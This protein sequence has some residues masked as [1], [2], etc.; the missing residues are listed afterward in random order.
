MTLTKEKLIVVGAI[1][2]LAVVALGFEKPSESSEL[3]EP[4]ETLE[5]PLGNSLLPIYDSITGKNSTER[6]NIKSQEFSKIGS[7]SRVIENKYGFEIEVQSISKIEGG[8][9]I[10][11]RA[12]D[13]GSPVGFGDGTVEMERFKI[14]NPP[15]MVP[16]PL[17]TYERVFVTDERTIIQR[18]REDP[19]A[20]LLQTLAHTISIIGKDGSKIVKGRIGNTTSTFFPDDD[21]E[22]NTMDGIVLSFNE[23]TW[24]NA[25]DQTDP[26]VGSED[27][28]GTAINS[29]AEQEADSQWRIRRAFAC[30]RHDHLYNAKSVGGYNYRRR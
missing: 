22:T 13:K 8:I 28:S 11:A 19:E 27:D 21:P 6:A 9:E 4:P 7:V 20:A 26:G 25:H 14:Y 16:D 29:T 10:L 12:W 17:G 2:L 24:D 23:T 1:L 18:F 5:I 30:N 15:I 3:S